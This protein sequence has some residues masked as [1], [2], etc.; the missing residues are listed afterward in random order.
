MAK[1]ALS[2]LCVFFIILLSGCA[3]MASGSPLTD[4]SADFTAEFNGMNLSGTVT[5]DRRGIL[6]MEIESPETLDG[7]MIS[8]RN[9]EAEIKR[10]ELICTADEAYLPR[11]SLPSMLN[12]ALAAL[13]DGLERK[14]AKPQNGCY[15]LETDATEY[16][17]HIE[18]NG[19]IT[20]ISASDGSMK[21]QFENVTAS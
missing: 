2:A 16:D 21:I 15:R 1:K 12:G 9:G 20:Q 5:A 19:F 13:N 18:N 3:Y 8:Y 6:C 17:I 14:E 10:N 4:F 7:L 11:S